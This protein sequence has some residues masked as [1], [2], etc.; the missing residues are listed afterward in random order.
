[1][2][3]MC[4]PA[5][6]GQVENNAATRH[7][8]RTAATYPGVPLSHVLPSTDSAEVDISS[9]SPASSV[10]CC[11]RLPR[12]LMNWT[13]GISPSPTHPPF[14]LWF[15][16]SSFPPEKSH[17][18]CNRRFFLLDS[19]IPALNEGGLPGPLYSRAWGIHACQGA[20]TPPGSTI[21][22]E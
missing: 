12:S 4:S 3:S 15:S 5:H 7:C 1:M 19:P 10:L 13:Y 2:M 8:V 11:V 16:C 6:S 20:S 22:R 9:C 14:V 21:A 18:R 17:L